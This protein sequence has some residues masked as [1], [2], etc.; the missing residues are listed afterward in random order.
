MACYHPLLAFKCDGKVVFNKPFA[1]AKGFNLPCGQCWGCRLQ[2]SREWAIRCMHE[3]QMHEHNSFITLTIN[4][5]TLERRPRPWSLDITEFQKFMKRLRKK[6]G[7]D[8]R[9][10]HCGEYGDENKRP[11]YHALIFGYDFPD[12]T[13][14]EK[15]LG[16]NLYI[17]PELEE[18][19][20]HGFHRIGSCTY[21][22]AAYVARYVM[23]KAKGEGSLE[24]HVNQ[25]TGEIEY[26]LDNQYATMSRR[27][28][29]GESWYWKYGWTDAH[30][31]DYI[32]HENIKMKVP[33][34]Y[35]K[36]L[37]KYDPEYHQELK[38]KRKAQAPEV[39]TE[40]N[41]AMDQLWV[42]EEIKIKKLERL[43][44]NL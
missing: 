37:E 32:V 35:D 34:Y 29:I 38:N 44:R 14:W 15:K 22:S 27:A 33:R 10:F 6:T 13:L 30:R 43:I 24:Q 17:S 4:P 7:K 19:W 21:E 3:A 39:I 9:F 5:E 18:L 23:K 1:F 12:K 36:Q 42:S 41:K 31:H 28:G 11:H 16:N 2:H 20:P 8:I 40:Y 25:D 26:D